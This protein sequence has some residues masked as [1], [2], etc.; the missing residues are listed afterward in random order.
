MMFGEPIF[1]RLPQLGTDRL[2][3]R[4]MTMADAQDIFAYS[5][6]PE[7]S[8]YVLWDAHR[9]IHDSRAYLRYLQRQ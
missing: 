4:R 5:R 3:L 9:S 1:S 2:I 8:R 6:D 7:V